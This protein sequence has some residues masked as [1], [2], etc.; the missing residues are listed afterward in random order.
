[1]LY[2]ASITS[3]KPTTPPPKKKTHAHTKK[4]KEKSHVIPAIYAFRFS[5]FLL[6][7][8]RNLSRLP[9]ANFNC[10]HYKVGWKCYAKSKIGLCKTTLQVLGTTGYVDVE[11]NNAYGDIQVCNSRKW[12]QIYG[13]DGI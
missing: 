3:C 6:F 2:H 5:C 11:Q 9:S 4:E 10:K 13:A 7:Y 8:T 1:M 12:D